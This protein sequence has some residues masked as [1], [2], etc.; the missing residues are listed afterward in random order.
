MIKK[1]TAYVTSDGTE[2]KSRT[3]AKNHEDMILITKTLAAFINKRIPGVK[4]SLKDP[5]LDQLGL[6]EV[7]K[8][9]TEPTFREVV[10]TMLTH[11]EE[12]REALT[13]TRKRAPKTDKGDSSKAETA[14]KP[15]PAKKV[16]PAKVK[17]ATEEGEAPKRR[18][19]PKGSKNKDTEPAEV[20]TKSASAPLP[21]LPPPPPPP[22][23]VG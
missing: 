10:E 9:E 21:N 12:L 23:P 6:P 14:P 2:H 1:V 5:L 7:Y 16:K 22:P 15:G 20:T 17:P 13:F 8:E 19:R 3:D 18:G 4:V 11:R